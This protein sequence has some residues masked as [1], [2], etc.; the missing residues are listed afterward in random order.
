MNFNLELKKVN[1]NAMPQSD[2][3]QMK[4]IIPPADHTRFEDNEIETRL[5]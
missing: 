5:H 4:K 1:D 2:G 3:D